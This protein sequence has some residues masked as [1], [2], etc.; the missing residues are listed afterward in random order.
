[1]EPRPE[2]I[3]RLYEL[4]FTRYLNSSM[5]P[6]PEK[7]HCKW[8]GGKAARVWCCEKCREEGYVR[9][10]YVALRLF[11]RDKGVCVKCGL[12]AEWLK[13]QIYTIRRVA[14][15]DGT[16]LYSEFRRILGWAHDTSRRFWEA[17]HIIPVSEGGG[18]CGLENFQTLCVPCHKKESA[19]LAKKRAKG[20]KV[21]A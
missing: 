1:M 2:I 15:R 17:D 10:G 12:D 7:G 18:C 8:C 3:T 21:K 14:K 5:L 19:M 20:N 16:Y 6:K 4:R 13:Q 9:M 11:R